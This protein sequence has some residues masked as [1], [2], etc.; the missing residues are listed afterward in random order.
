[1]P[2]AQLPCT[3]NS[4]LALL[5]ADASGTDPELLLA[6]ASKL[7]DAVLQGGGFSCCCVVGGLLLLLSL[8]QRCCCS[9]AVMA[10]FGSS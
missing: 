2:H 5:L 6:V 3:T 4:F 10:L 1:M 8:L 9:E 7:G